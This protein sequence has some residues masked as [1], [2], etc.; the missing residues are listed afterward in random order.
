MTLELPMSAL[1]LAHTPLLVAWPGD[2][3]AQRGR[4]GCAPDRDGGL[5]TTDAHAVSHE[6]SAA[7]RAA[8][9]RQLLRDEPRVEERY[10]QYLV[11]LVRALTERG[12]TL[13]VTDVHWLEDLVRGARPRGMRA[14]RAERRRQPCISEP[15]SFSCRA[16][17]AAMNWHCGSAFMPRLFTSSRA[18]AARREPKPWP[19]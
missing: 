3:L 10:V 12:S 18:K 7:M 1:G 11:G 9:F 8:D 6:L 17:Y 15:Y 4:G 2:R 16:M 14:A 13:E 5:R 19:S